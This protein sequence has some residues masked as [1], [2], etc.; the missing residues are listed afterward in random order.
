MDLSVAVLAG[1][2]SAEAEVSRSSARQVTEAL[3]QRYPRV[4]LLEVDDNLHGGL[5][6]MNPS[7]VFPVLHGPP[8][9]DGTLQGFLEILGYCYVGSDVHGS[10]A[11]M[12]KRLAKLVF[13]AADLPVLDDMLIAADADPKRAAR[14]IKTTIG[15]RVVIKPTNQGSAIGV[16]P[17]PNGGELEAPLREAMRF[18]GALIEPYVVGREITVGVLDLEGQAA[19][20]LP[21]IEVKTA[22][23]EWYDFENRYTAG[24][25][26]HVIPAELPDEVLVRLQEIAVTG[27]QALQLRDLSRADFIVDDN[28]AIHLLEINTLPGMTPTS[29]YPDGAAAAGLPFVDLVAELVESAYRRCR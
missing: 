14:D 6:S 19:R 13:R 5:A 10:A 25:S 29:L 17:L 20:A 9:E 18:G 23:D 11:A 15:D 4:Q 8:G 3:S 28:N 21:V 12:D 16:T 26:Q 22:N 7:V 24:K 27:H 1:G 2:I